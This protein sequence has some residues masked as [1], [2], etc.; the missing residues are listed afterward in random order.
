MTNSSS[1]VAAHLQRHA[2]TQEVHEAQKI[3]HH[4]F[5]PSLRKDLD[6]DC[7]VHLLPLICRDPSLPLLHSPLT[8]PMASMNRS[9]SINSLGYLELV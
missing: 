9:G 8:A 4:P 5:H 7:A 1:Q 2:I 6:S 3:N